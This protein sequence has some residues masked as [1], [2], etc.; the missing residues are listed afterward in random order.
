M[1]PYFPQEHY[2]DRPG[3]PANKRA[4]IIAGAA[5]AHAVLFG[6]FGI[7]PGLDG[8]L[9]VRPNP[10][11]CG[12]AAVRGFL[13]RGHRLDVTMEPGRIE[14]ALDGAPVYAGEPRE[15]RVL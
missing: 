12:K 6:L 15:V 14:V 1:L 11:V 10:E 4:N 8:S 5:G 13:Y 7:T 2:C 9:R 3:V